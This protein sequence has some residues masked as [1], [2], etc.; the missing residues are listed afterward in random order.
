[1]NELDQL[2]I[3]YTEKEGLIDRLSNYY[4]LQN[5]LEFDI[6]LLRLDFRLDIDFEIGF[7]LFERQ[8]NA[9]YSELREYD[10]LI[11]QTITE[12]ELISFKISNL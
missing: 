1:M 10:V 5:G 7:D 4:H 2:K 12:I 8:I 9:L 11:I 6:T 3:F